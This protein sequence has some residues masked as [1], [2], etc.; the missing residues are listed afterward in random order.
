MA[1]VKTVW[2]F[3]VGPNV[4]RAIEIAGYLSRAE[5]DAVREAREFWVVRDWPDF[6]APLPFQPHLTDR[7]M[8]AAPM[9]RP[10]RIT[11]GRLKAK[12]PRR[13]KAGR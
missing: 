10:A 5:A 8:A 7:M 1:A 3:F 12:A 11:L 4:L 9:S 13:S 6:G 2:H